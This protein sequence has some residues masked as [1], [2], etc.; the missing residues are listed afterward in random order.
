MKCDLLRRDSLESCC[1]LVEELASSQVS[2]KLFPLGLDKRSTEFCK[3]GCNFPELLRLT[4]GVASL[5]LACDFR[6]V[7]ASLLIFHA[8]PLSSYD[9]P[10]RHSLTTGTKPHHVPITL[11]H[12]ANYHG[13]S[14]SSRCGSE[15][16]SD[17]DSLDTDQWSVQVKVLRIAP[18]LPHHTAVA[19]R[20]SCAKHG[21]QAW[22]QKHV[23]IHPPCRLI[24]EVLLLEFVA[25]KINGPCRASR[26]EPVPGHPA[27]P[28][29]Y[30][31]IHIPSCS[32]SSVFIFLTCLIYRFAPPSH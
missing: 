18:L 12:V 24:V 11:K 6:V 5:D 22:R 9:H 2:S 7:K 19:Q 10:C 13:Q 27:L 1:K 8:R 3:S 25:Y 23:L 15:P 4:D 21:K 16:Q 14:D 26:S 31:G 29:N 30:R 32:N 28:G 20:H 17:T